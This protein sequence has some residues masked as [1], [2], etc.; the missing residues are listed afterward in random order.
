MDFV[1]RPDK[2]LARLLTLYLQVRSLAQATRD[3]YC[4]AVRNLA[5]SMRRPADLIE[6]HQVGIEEIAHHKQEILSRA[7]DVTW[8]TERRHLSALLNFAVKLNWAESNVM[9]LVPGVLVFR[10]KVKA[11]DRASFDAYVEFLM[12]HK[13]RDK[14]GH[15]VDILP[16]QWF[17]LAVLTTLFFTGMRKAQ[18]VGLQWGDIDLRAGT[19]NLR[20]ET[21]K[22]KRE[23]KIAMATRLRP[24]LELL[25]AR[26]IEARRREPFPNEQVFCLPLFS[27]W[28]KNFRKGQMVKDNVDNF[29]QRLRQVAPKAL[30]VLSAHRVRHTTATILANSVP[31]L[32]VVQELLGHTTIKTT[33]GYVHVNLDDMKRA[34]D[35]L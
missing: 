14:R 23:W 33:Y 29:F 28:R 25:L 31:N 21:S 10:G 30:P 32:K 8:N 13:Q 9:A 11:L 7:T 6:I 4:L 24:Q 15:D 26:T 2:S 5:R 35:L 16:P 3:R 12:R 18:L 19:I 34:T 20:A 1:E 22:T 27:I 17:W